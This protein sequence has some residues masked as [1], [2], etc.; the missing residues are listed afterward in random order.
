MRVC[1]CGMCVRVSEW[2]TDRQTDRQTDRKTDRQ[3]V[4]KPNTAHT[5][6][7]GK[8]GSRRRRKNVQ[9]TSRSFGTLEKR[10]FM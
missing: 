8:R 3:C 9:S 4:C 6:T 2:V 10:F 5:H 1:V 7:L